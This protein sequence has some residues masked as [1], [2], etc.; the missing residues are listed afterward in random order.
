MRFEDLMS[1]A[2]PTLPPQRRHERQPAAAAFA[3]V[4]PPADAA[5]ALPLRC[6]AELSP[7][8]LRRHYAD[9]RHDAAEAC[10]KPRCLR[11][12]CFSS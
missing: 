3:D 8:R 12:E 9:G 5:H 4:S 10:A 6:H 2:T 1:A 7:T 11:H